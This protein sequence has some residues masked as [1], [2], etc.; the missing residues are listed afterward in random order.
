MVVLKLTRESSFL[1]GLSLQIIIIGLIIFA[2]T[3]A[4]SS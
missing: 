2:E 3:S 4:V 1:N